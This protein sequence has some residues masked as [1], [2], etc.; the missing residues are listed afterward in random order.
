MGEVHSKSKNWEVFK[1]KRSSVPAC[2]LSKVYKGFEGI[3]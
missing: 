1:V 2:N 3:E